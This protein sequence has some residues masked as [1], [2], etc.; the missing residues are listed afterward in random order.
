MSKGGNAWYKNKK[1]TIVVYIHIMTKIAKKKKK[2]TCKSVIL[3]TNVQQIKPGRQK[4]SY[5]W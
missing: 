2:K 1:G 3:S 5:E 4:D